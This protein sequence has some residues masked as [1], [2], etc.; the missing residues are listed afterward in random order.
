MRLH[1]GPGSRV[2]HEELRRSHFLTGFVEV[3]Q[4][5]RLAFDD[6]QVM[7]L[8]HDWHELLR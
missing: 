1:L 6:S 7:P 3:E 2:D 5:L 8:R 4:M